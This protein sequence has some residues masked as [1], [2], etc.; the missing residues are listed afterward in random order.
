MGRSK[1]ELEEQYPRTQVLRAGAL[2]ANGVTPVEPNPDF[3][4]D[5]RRAADGKGII[6]ACEGGGSTQPSASFQWVSITARHVP[7]GS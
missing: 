3:L 2:L 7:A 1:Q 6:L 4:E 5:V